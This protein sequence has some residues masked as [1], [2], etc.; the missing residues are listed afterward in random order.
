[1][2][3]SKN[4]KERLPDELAGENQQLETTTR[5]LQNYPTETI[6]K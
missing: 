4:E 1:M 2:G 3:N 5:R 6:K